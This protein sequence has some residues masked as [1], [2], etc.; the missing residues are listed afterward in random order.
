MSNGKEAGA[1]KNSSATLPDDIAGEVDLFVKQIDSLAEMLPLST[2]AM[3]EAVEASG[4]QFGEFFDEECT[5]IEQTTEKKIYNID[6]GQY[7]HLI[8]LLRR[9]QKTQLA[10]ELVPR[11]LFV[12]LVSQFDAYLGRILRQLFKI[13]PEI[14]TASA[15]TLTFAQLI[16]FGS[17]E[18]AREYIIDKEIESILRKNHSEQFDWL[19]N[20][21]GLPLRT[22]L[23][24][25]TLFV[26]ITE[27]RNLFVHTNGVVSHQYLEVCQRHK[28]AVPSDVAPGKSLSISGE[29]FRAAYDCLFEIGIKLAQVL[30]RKVEPDKMASADASLNRVCY[31]LLVEGR[32]RLARVLLDFGTETLKKHSSEE[33]RLLLVVNR[34]Q[35][36]KWTGEDEKSR[37]ILDAEDWSATSLKFKLA[38]AV[39]RDDHAVALQLMS[40]IGTDGEMNKHFYREWPLFK[41]IRK[42]REFAAKFE[43]VFG[44][45]YT[46]IIVDE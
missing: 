6:P 35:T 27:R 14:L 4:R 3:D 15:N 16:E 26:E 25:W 36:Y 17:I 43:E 22:N 45:P 7:S 34:A 24:A 20:K 30:W 18:N 41:E 19:E 32:Y 38:C 23:P 46:A 29:Y 8:R 37:A 39:L 12:S 42:S 1:D 9:I 5:K 11:S 44:E 10:Q 2:L 13:K 21:L 31:E 33:S 40:Q 28:C